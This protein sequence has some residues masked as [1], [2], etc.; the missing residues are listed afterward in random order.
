MFVTD[1]LIRAF[2]LTTG[3]LRAKVNLNVDGGFVTN[4]ASD[5]ARVYATGTTGVFAFSC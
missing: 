3:V 1:F 2:D 5:G 4:L